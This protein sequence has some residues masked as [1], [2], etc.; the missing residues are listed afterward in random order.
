MPA[1]FRPVTWAVQEICT[2]LI[3]MICQK[4]L[5]SGP[6]FVPSVTKTQPGIKSISAAASATSCHR[7]MCQVCIP[8]P[9]GCTGHGRQPF[10]FGSQQTLN[11]DF[12]VLMSVYIE[13][14][15]LTRQTSP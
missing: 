12:R 11:L 2:L 3:S 4:R 13:E 10:Y 9:M 7:V 1:L 5:I 15:W 6:N 14:P 8:T